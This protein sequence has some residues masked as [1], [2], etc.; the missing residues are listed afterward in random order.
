LEEILGMSKF[1][2]EEWLVYTAEKKFGATKCR[3]KT[4][5]EVKEFVKD[6]ETI[7]ED[8]IVS[9]GGYRVDGKSLMGILSLNLEKYFEIFSKNFPKKFQEKWGV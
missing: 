9:Q 4:F 5:D 6:M 2:I 8:V 7:N 1:I 3:L